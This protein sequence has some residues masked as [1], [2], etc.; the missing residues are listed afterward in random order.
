MAFRPVLEI[1][2][3]QIWT[4]LT[5]LHH[6]VQVNFSTRQG[7][8]APQFIYPTVKMF[9]K[10]SYSYVC[11]EGIIIQLLSIYLSKQSLI[12]LNFSMKSCNLKW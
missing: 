12:S 7:E 4:V 2:E 3:V 8:G 11:S 1:N 9:Q 5:T 6:M 10:T